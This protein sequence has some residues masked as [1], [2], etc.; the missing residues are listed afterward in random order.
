LH[1][2]SALFRFL[3]VPDGLGDLRW[4]GTDRVLLLIDWI[5]VI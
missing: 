4:E 2:A 1:C 3:D 5:L